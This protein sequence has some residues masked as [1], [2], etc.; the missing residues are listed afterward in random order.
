MT[1]ETPND[2]IRNS[3]RFAGGG[4]A[5][6]VER[7]RRGVETSHFYLVGNRLNVNADSPTERPLNIIPAIKRYAVVTLGKEE[8]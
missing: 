1:R 8:A 3:H 6:T 4:F 2:S 5:G 7:Q